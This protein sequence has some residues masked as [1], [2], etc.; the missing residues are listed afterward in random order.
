MVRDAS[1]YRVRPW[2]LWEQ[3][4]EGMTANRALETNLSAQKTRPAHHRRDVHGRSLRFR[5]RDQ[6]QWSGHR[7]MA[8]TCDLPR[9]D[10]ELLSGWS[11]S[12]A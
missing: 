6:M 10:R 11:V 2:L 9:V 12:L 7:A 5:S 1:L 4:V 3:E 8:E